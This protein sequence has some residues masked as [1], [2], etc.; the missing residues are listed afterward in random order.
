MST[1]LEQA[2][3]R[4]IDNDCTLTD[5]LFIRRVQPNSSKSE[6]YAEASG[7][8]S[9]FA[10][11]HL[12]VQSS[13]QIAQIFDKAYEK[14]ISSRPGFSPQDF[15][16]YAMSILFDETE[17][18][19]EAIKIHRGAVKYLAA[20]KTNLS[21]DISALADDSKVDFSR[22]VNLSAQE[23]NSEAT[24][25]ASHPGAQSR[26]HFTLPG[27][28]VDTS[29]SELDEDRTP[30]PDNSP[31]FRAEFYHHRT[32]ADLKNAPDKPFT[33][34]PTHQLPHQPTDGSRQGFKARPNDEY[35]RRNE[36]RDGNKA[37]PY[38][39]NGKKRTFEQQRYGQLYKR[40]RRLQLLLVILIL[41]FSVSKLHT[42][43][44]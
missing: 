29:E 42:L 23:I 26:I 19:A 36:L 37:V 24:A 20:S 38:A 16:L 30:F 35:S 21:P 34:F 31:H 4:K 40:Y 33:R 13:K 9:H 18:D 43:T 8:L 27:E 25:A 2:E 44:W 12:T 11:L 3:L 15:T 41:A 28:P 39:K 1:G 17:D 7:A 10:G 5:F 22:T 6:V 14:M 32:R